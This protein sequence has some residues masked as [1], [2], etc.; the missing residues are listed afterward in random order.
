MRV[1]R[2]WP[3]PARR[4]QSGR[5]VYGYEVDDACRGVIKAAAGYGPYFIHRTGHSIDTSDHG[6]GVNIDNLE[7]Q[8]RRRLIPG[9]GFR[10]NRAFTCPVRASACVWRSTATWLQADVEVTTLPLQDEVILLG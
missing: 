8:D 4:L 1:I 6:N 9:V 10:S 2:Q 7:T 3:L 5:P